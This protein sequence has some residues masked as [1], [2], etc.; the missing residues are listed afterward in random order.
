MSNVYENEHYTVEVV[1]AL[2]TE[3]V[4]VPVYGLVNKATSVREGEFP[5]FPQAIQ[6]SDQLS[7]SILELEAKED[8]TDVITEDG[9]VGLEYSH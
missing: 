3:P 4:G 8:P 1:D 9:V 6:Y 2:L 7:G 5:Y